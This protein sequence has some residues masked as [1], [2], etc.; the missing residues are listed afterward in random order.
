[1]RK[2][3]IVCRGNG[4]STQCTL[5]WS[6]CDGATGRGGVYGSQGATAESSRRRIKG[7]TYRASGRRRVDRRGI[8]DCG[9]AGGRVVHIK[10][11]RVAANI[12]GRRV[13]VHGY[14]EGAACTTAVNSITVVGRGNARG[15]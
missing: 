15:S 2:I 5:G 14:G 8:L 6:E 9:G 4:V 3:T 7:E 11:R 10:G 12:G 1:M 13:G